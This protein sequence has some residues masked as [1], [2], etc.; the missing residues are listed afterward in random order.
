M[1]LPFL[2]FPWV[3]KRDGTTQESEN[4]EQEEEKKQYISLNGFPSAS[5]EATYRLSCAKLPPL[6]A[7][8]KLLD[9]PGGEQADG[10]DS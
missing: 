1:L 2:E 5:L 7:T 4:G 9:P 6:V 10:P 8:A 3:L